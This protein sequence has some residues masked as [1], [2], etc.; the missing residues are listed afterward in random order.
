M[1]LRVYLLHGFLAKTVVVKWK[2]NSVYT[3]VILLFMT[4]VIG[5]KN[6]EIEKLV[7]T[8]HIYSSY[9]LP[10]LNFRSLKWGGSVITNI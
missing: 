4:I 7:N 5:H 10:N 3:T 9:G 6:H 1:C 8:I 2:I